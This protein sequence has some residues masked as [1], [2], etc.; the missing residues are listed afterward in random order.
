MKKILLVDDSDLV[1]EVIGEALRDGGFEV[2]RARDGYEAIE[3]CYRV[4]PDLVIMDIDMPLLKGYQASR[5]LKSR[6]GVKDIPIIMHTGNSEDKDRFWSYNSGACAFVVKD[7]GNIGPLVDKV[8]SFID[9]EPLDTALIVEDAKSINREFIAESLSN[10]LDKELYHSTIINQLNDAARSISSLSGTVLRVL[11]LLDLACERDIA[12][13]ILKI[14]REAV[15]YV[16]PQATVNKAM[17]DDFLSVAFEDFYKQFQLS[18]VKPAE[19]QFF[20]LEERADWNK[21]RLDKV[22][23]CSYHAAPIFGSAGECVGTIHLGHVKNNY[24]AESILE[25]IGAFVRDAGVIIHNAMLFNQL[26]S[27]ERDIR[28]IFSKFVPQE[29]INDLIA[30]R[31]HT[32]MLAGEKR[33]L[34]IV[35]SD[36]R[37]FT[38]LSENNPP[39]VVVSFLNR[40]LETMCDIITDHGG[41]VDKFI[42]DAILAVF[43]APKSWPDNARRAV[44]TAMAMSRALAVFD[45]T[46]IQLPPEGLEI[47]IGV[48]LGDAIVG[49]IGSSAKFDYTV[50]GDTVNL[51]SRLEGLSK[52]YLCRIIV[53]DRIVKAIDAHKDVL[54][55]V[56]FREIEEVIVKGKEEPTLIYQLEDEGL[57]SLSDAEYD[58]YK[59]AQA[60]YRLRNWQTAIDYFSKVLAAKPHDPVCIMFR[61]R[62][63]DF[64]LTP[65]PADWDFVQRYLTK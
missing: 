47:G 39:E 25:N 52:Q 4:I 5:L 29:I 35:F 8:N 11:E 32:S 36:I 19:P 21:L 65:P 24:F 26:S 15:P 37:S 7:Y 53:S 50:I 62:C 38:T 49:T 63:Q 17:A 40:Y 18:S 23:L 43:G 42:G 10:I 41:M 46:G 13:V 54:E 14:G 12:A 20:N 45:T 61:Q 33:E 1:A 9:Y 34:A 28:H 60:M 2:V 56:R 31:T 57:P 27:M 48:H 64:L 51:A 30:R 3:Q 6:R 59:K 55:G 16:F 22:R 44:Q 58:L